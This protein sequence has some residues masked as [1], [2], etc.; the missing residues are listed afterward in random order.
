MTGAVLWIE[1]NPY[2]GS[3]ENTGHT[4]KKRVHAGSSADRRTAAL[5]LFTNMQG[6][7]QKHTRTRDTKD[8]RNTRN[9]RNTRTTRNARNTRTTR[10]TRVRIRSTQTANVA[11]AGGLCR[12]VRPS[13]SSDY[14][15]HWP[16]PSIDQLISSDGEENWYWNSSTELCCLEFLSRVELPFSP[17]SSFHPRQGWPRD[18]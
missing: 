14:I 3:P 5:L 10:D 13:P 16:K 11:Q 12:I 2:E 4:S 7:N 8:T 1:I 15:R 17:T 6:A 18:G 9:T